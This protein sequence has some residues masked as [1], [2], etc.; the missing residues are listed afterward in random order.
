MAIDATGIPDEGG[1]DKSRDEFSPDAG[2]ESDASSRDNPGWKTDTSGRPAYVPPRGRANLDAAR[3]DRGLSEDEAEKAAKR[4]PHDQVIS[5]ADKRVI[6]FQGSQFIAH[7]KDDV[8]FTRQGDVE[9]KFLVPFEFK[10]LVLDL[11]NAFGVPLSIDVQVWQ[12]FKEFEDITSGE[13]IE[14]SGSYKKGY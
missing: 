4:A 14:G 3:R 6:K 9:I 8:K 13:V 10:H 1:L 7:L 2:T 5:F 11:T 12:P